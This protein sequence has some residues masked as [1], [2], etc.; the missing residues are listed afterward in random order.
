MKNTIKIVSGVLPEDGK[1]EIDR[2]NMSESKKLADPKNEEFAVA[3]E[4]PKK[5]L[6]ALK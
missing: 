5:R 6:S 2:S 4:Q 1:A 3:P